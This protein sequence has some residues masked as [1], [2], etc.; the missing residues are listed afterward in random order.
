MIWLAKALQCNH[1]PYYHRNAPLK[2]YVHIT[3]LRTLLTSEDS[4]EQYLTFHRIA[5]QNTTSPLRYKGFC[6]FRKT[7]IYKHVHIKGMEQAFKRRRGEKLD[8]SFVNDLAKFQRLQQAFRSLPFRKC[9]MSQSSQK[10]D[11]I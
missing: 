9:V 8:S 2:F 5:F 10:R 1:I 3:Y 4:Q 11:V 6:S 7:K